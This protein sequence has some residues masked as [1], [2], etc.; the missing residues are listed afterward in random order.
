MVHD[1]GVVGNGEPGSVTDAYAYNGFNDLA[2][3]TS[4]YAG[5]PAVTY[6][7]LSANAVTNSRTRWPVRPS[8]DQRTVAGTSTTTVTNYTY[9][10]AGQLTSVKA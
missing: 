4:K 9:D 3:I 2:S 10:P 1:S 7:D 6:D 8:E 5:A